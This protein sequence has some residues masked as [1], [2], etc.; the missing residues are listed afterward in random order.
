MELSKEQASFAIICFD[1]VKHATEDTMKEQPEDSPEREQDLQL[2][3]YTEDMINRC[4]RFLN[5][6]PE[7]HT[8]LPEGFDLKNMKGLDGGDVVPIHKLGPYS[9]YEIYLLMEGVKDGL[10]AT[11]DKIDYIEDEANKEEFVFNCMN[12]GEEHRT[13]DTRQAR[14]DGLNLQKTVLEKFI[15]QLA[16]AMYPLDA[17][18]AKNAERL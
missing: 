7:P 17:M 2:L 18:A 4:I 13:L 3:M 8:L 11:L 15:H 12:E 5:G 10:S 16:A 14:L 9:T 6:D 1:M